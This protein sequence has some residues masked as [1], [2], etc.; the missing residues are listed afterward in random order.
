MDIKRMYG[1]DLSKKVQKSEKFS[2]SFR[3]RLLF[4]LVLIL[5]GIM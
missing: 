3:G 5:M 1:E 4:G 2:S